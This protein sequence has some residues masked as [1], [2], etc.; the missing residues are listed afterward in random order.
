MKYSYE[1][2]DRVLKNGNIQR[3][4]LL[5]HLDPKLDMVSSFLESDIQGGSVQYVLDNIDK[6]LSGELDHMEMTGN[7]CDVN[8]YKDKTTIENLFNE[9]EYSEIETIELREFVVLWGEETKRF[10]KENR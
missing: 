7:L 2:E 5:I 3:K 9:D 1:F 4:T 6:V 10:Y 8:I